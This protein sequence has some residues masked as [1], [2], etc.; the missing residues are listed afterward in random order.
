MAR[1]FEVE[2]ERG[3]VVAEEVVQLARDAEPFVGAAGDLQQ[4]GRHSQLRVRLG[5]ALARLRLLVRDAHGD[6]REEAVKAK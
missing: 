5:E 6:E 2:A 4:L 1:H 3:E